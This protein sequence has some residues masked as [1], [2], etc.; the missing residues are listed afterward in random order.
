MK[1]QKT[2]KKKKTK[3]KTI[4][5]TRL[6]VGGIKYKVTPGQHLRVYCKFHNPG[7]LESKTLEEEREGRRK[8]K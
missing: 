5:S 4:N 1:R 2:K 8:C 7:V 3:S 6:N